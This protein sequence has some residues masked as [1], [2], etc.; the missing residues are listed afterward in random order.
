[1]YFYIKPKVFLPQRIHHPHL[2]SALNQLEIKTPHRI[3][4]T[5]RRLVQEIPFT[6]PEP[7]LNRYKFVCLGPLMA[8]FPVIIRKTLK[9]FYK[10]YS[11]ICMDG[12]MI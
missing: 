12:N 4:I 3:K 2:A 10:V 9:K 6:T 7:L 11:E 8:I 5:L 1:M